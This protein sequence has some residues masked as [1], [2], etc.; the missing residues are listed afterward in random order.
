MSSLRDEQLDQV[1]VGE[2]VEGQPDC[3]VAGGAEPGGVEGF[4]DR[5][6][7]VAAV[8]ELE[9]QGG[10]GVE[11]SCFPTFRVK[12]EDFVVDGFDDESCALLGDHG[13]FSAVGFGGA[14]TEIMLALRPLQVPIPPSGDDG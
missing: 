6:D 14:R 8:A 10:A 3:V 1:G 9:H 2:F 5:V 4:L 13:R 12:D 11:C 7:R